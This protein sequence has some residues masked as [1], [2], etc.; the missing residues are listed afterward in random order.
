MRVSKTQLNPFLQ[1]QLFLTLHQAIAD[2]KKPQEVEKFLK[3]FLATNEHETLA[4]RLAITYWLDKGRGWENIANNLKV[5]SATIA[6]VYQKMEREGVGLA[7]QKI[8][9]EEWSTKWS[10]KIK[11][12][13]K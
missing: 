9:A 11:K 2:L 6:N 8:K 13:V 7:L 1:K 4:K 12:F 5:S 10:E 3:A